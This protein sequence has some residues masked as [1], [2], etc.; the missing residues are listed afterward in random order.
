M[1]WRAVTVSTSRVVCH[2]LKKSTILSGTHIFTARKRSLRKLCFHR[3]LSVHREKG[4]CMVEGHAL[5]RVCVTGGMHGGGHV[6]WGHASH[7]ACVEGACMAG[8]MHDRRHM[9]QGGMCGRGH[10]WEGGMRGR[11][12]SHCSGRYVSYWNV[13]LLD[14]YFLHIQSYFMKDEFGSDCRSPLSRTSLCC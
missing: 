13:F 4:V 12:D 9:W 10:V 6:W 2:Q 5:K 11:R 3:C 8:G 14:I 7:G 1:Q